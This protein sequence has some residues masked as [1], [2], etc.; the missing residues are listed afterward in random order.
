MKNENLIVRESSAGNGEE[1]QNIVAPNADITETPEAYLVSLE[2]PGAR[3]EAIAL[4]L[5]KDVLT[6]HA[7]IGAHHGNGDTV[8][9]RELRSTGYH[10][11]FSLGEGLD[12][13]SVSAVFEDGVLTVKLFKTPESTPRTIPIN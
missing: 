4:T 6:V 2:M 3:K 7:E 8:L 10:R 12:P 1:Y 9:Y 5:A 11:E 13:N